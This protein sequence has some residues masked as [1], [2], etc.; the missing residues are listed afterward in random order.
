MHRSNY[1]QSRAR[2]AL[3][4]FSRMAYAAGLASCADIIRRRRGLMPGAGGFAS[5]LRRQEAAQIDARLA[6]AIAAA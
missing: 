6:F 5:I 1:R 4:G 3:I 2:R